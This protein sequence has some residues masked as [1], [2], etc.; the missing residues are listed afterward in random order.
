MEQSSSCGITS[1]GRVGE[2][3]QC[4]AV[5]I[6]NCRRIRAMVDKEEEKCERYIG[7]RCSSL[8]LAIFAS[9]TTS[10][11][12]TKSQ[13]VPDSRSKA[14]DKTSTLIAWRCRLSLHESREDIL[15][16]IEYLTTIAT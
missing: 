6:L 16:D 3:G 5:G 2:I 1:V 10:S 15:N 13:E 11:T 12:I 7:Q 9:T 8:F 14:K 4:I